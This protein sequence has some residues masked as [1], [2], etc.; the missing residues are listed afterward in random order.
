[1]EGMKACVGAEE[2]QM[3]RSKVLLGGREAEM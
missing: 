2:V 1:M 3:R